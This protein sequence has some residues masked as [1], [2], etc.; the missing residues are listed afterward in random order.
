MWFAECES[1]H[2]SVNCS[3]SA[4]SQYILAIHSHNDFDHREDVA[5]ILCSVSYSYSLTFLTPV[6]TARA[7]PLT[8][9]WSPK[10]PRIFS[11]PNS[12]FKALLES[13]REIEPLVSSMVSMWGSGLPFWNTWILIKSPSRCRYMVLLVCSAIVTALYWSSSA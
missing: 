3:F 5:H 9:F 12:S 8:S 13:D 2:S 10:M 4:F 6:M 11:E 7:Y 1:F